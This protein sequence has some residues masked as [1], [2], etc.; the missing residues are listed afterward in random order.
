MKVEVHHAEASVVEAMVADT[1][2][3]L[4]ALEVEVVL[5]DSSTSPM[6]VIP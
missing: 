2:E 5:L 3:A 4:E 1:W 6:F